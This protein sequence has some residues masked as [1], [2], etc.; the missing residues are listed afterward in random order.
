[1]SFLIL[2]GAQLSITD[3]GGPTSA[4]RRE[5]S[6]PLPVAASGFRLRWPEGVRAHVHPPWGMG[7]QQHH[8]LRLGSRQAW[9]SLSR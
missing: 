1:M 6:P 2:F 9:F 5:E 8:A 3:S 4:F 7:M